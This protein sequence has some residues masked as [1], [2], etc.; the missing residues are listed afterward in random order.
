MGGPGIWLG[1]VFGLLCA[2]LLLM[3][4][5]WTR[6]IQRVPYADAVARA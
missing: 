3:W 5:F 6:V 4:R 1:L 2:F